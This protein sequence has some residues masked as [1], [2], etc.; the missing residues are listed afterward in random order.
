MAPVVARQLEHA[1]Y[2][3]VFTGNGVERFLRGQR[4]VDAEFRW[5][6]ALDLRSIASMRKARKPRNWARWRNHSAWMD[7]LESVCQ[8]RAGW[9]S[10]AASASRRVPIQGK[11][12]PTDWEAF[13][14]CSVGVDED[15]TSYDLAVVASWRRG[16]EDASRSDATRIRRFLR[17]RLVGFGYRRKHPMENGS[18][19]M[20]E[21][22]VSSLGEARKGR[23]FLDRVFQGE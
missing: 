19:M 17:E 4:E 7:T 15:E 18:L 1:G 6:E 16:E 2:V 20:L 14:V 12:L 11:G 3:N 22:P 9:D 5:L 23:R 8:P 21:R 13:L 10:R